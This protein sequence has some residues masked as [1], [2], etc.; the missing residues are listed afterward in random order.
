METARL[1]ARDVLLLHHIL[2]DSNPWHR[3]VRHLRSRNPLMPMLHSVMPPPWDEELERKDLDIYRHLTRVVERQFGFILCEILGLEAG[4]FGKGR[5]ERPAA[6]R[7]GKSVIP[8][9]G[10]GVFAAEDIRR[11]AFVTFYPGFIFT[12]P[13][14]RVIPDSDYVVVNANSANNVVMDGYGWQAEDIQAFPAGNL[15]P[16]YG[17]GGSD[18]MVFHERYE[19][20]KSKGKG[21]KGGGGGQQRDVRI[22]HK[23]RIGIGQIVNHAPSLEHLNLA[24]FPFRFPYLTDYTDVNQRAIAAA[25]QR[26]QQRQ[27][28]TVSDVPQVLSSGFSSA[29]CVALQQLTPHSVIRPV[30]TNLEKLIDRQHESRL[31]NALMR[32]IRRFVQ[33]GDYVDRH[34][35]RAAREAALALS[36]ATGEKELEEP[37]ATTVDPTQPPPPLTR[38]IARDR[39]SPWPFDDTPPPFPFDGLGYVALRDIPAGEELFW[40]YRFAGVGTSLVQQAILRTPVLHRWWYPH[41]Y[42]FIDE[43]EFF[44]RHV[45]GGDSS[46]SSSSA[47]E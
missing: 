12:N 17:G 24:P 8:G 3:S 32:R 47:S 44:L 2:F 21:S 15:P 18:E 43:R 5:F 45:K 23:N 6:L 16:A 19:K 29:L 31:S 42:H 46:S 41:W 39:E 26:Q 9:G 40:N 28:T 27:E 22:V 37:E 38:A 7:V 35:L 25:Q 13:D 10:L 4:A 30:D 33:Y 20:G 36:S 14:L 11:G 1:F 34:R